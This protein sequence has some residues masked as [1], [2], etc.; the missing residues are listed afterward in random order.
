MSGLDKQCW[1]PCSCTRTENAQLFPTASVDRAQKQPHQRGQRSIAL[2][3][4]ALGQAGHNHGHVVHAARIAAVH[5]EARRAHAVV[6]VAVRLPRQ[7][8]QSACGVCPTPSPL[9]RAG[10]VHGGLCGRTPHSSSAVGGLP[11]AHSTNN[12]SLPATVA[13]RGWNP[14]YNSVTWACG[15]CNT[16]PSWDQARPCHTHAPHC[17]AR[18]ASQHA[19]SGKS[20][21]SPAIAGGILIHFCWLTGCSGS[22]P[23]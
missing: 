15:I 12:W 5:R 8:T 23:G 9:G 21:S 20:H 7:E 2:V 13:M 19:R 17:G 22:G 11:R 14:R 3:A 1:N 10:R 4:G 18:R 6:V 16:D